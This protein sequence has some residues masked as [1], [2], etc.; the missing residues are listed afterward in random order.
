MREFSNAQASVGFLSGAD[1]LLTRLLLDY[2]VFAEPK[3]HGRAT[4]KMNKFARELRMSDREIEA[5]RALV[6]QLRKGTVT[7]NDALDQL[8]ALTPVHQFTLKWDDEPLMAA[9]AKRYVQALRPDSGIA[10]HETDR[11]K[12]PRGAN[13]AGRKAKAVPAA[14]ATAA[15]RRDPETFI[16]VGVF[17]TRDFKK[18]EVIGLKG[19]VADLTEEE[20]DEMRLSGGRSDFSVLWSE[21][22]NCFCL[23]LG[24]A[25]FVN[26]DCRNNV[27]FQLTGANMSFKVLE[28]IKKDEELFT[29]YGEH[30]FDKNNASCLC[31]TCEELKQGAFASKKPKPAE[32]KARASSPTAGSRKS[33]RASTI[34]APDY[35]ESR[36][37]A[38][39]SAGHSA[40][41]QRSAAGRSSAGL[42]RSSS[43]PSLAS[44]S[45]SSPARARPRS[46]RMNPTRGAPSPADALRSGPRGVI[47]PK[48]PPPPAYAKDYA[49]DAKRRVARYTGPTSC[50][51]DEA[52]LVAAKRKGALSRSQSAPSVVALGKR[53]RSTADADSPLRRS[54]RESKKPR[55]SVVKLKQVRLG[56]RSS[57]RLSGTGATASARDRTFAK[58]RMAMGGDEEDSDLSELSEEE[59]EEEEEEDDAEDEQAAD[60]DEAE[61]EDAKMVEA[62]LLSPQRSTPAA[63][64]TSAQSPLPFAMPS[65]T[66]PTRSSTG[67]GSIAVTATASVTLTRDERSTRS[68]TAETTVSSAPPSASTVA[69]RSLAV[70]VGMSTSTPA[71]ERPSP[72]LRYA[73][74]GSDEL[75]DRIVLCEVPEK[76]K[77]RASP[78]PSASPAAAASRRI[79]LGAPSPAFYSASG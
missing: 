25:R 38:S 72:Q 78:A 73:S 12:N 7:V 75:E 29:H 46:S 9:H 31:A 77:G 10:F 79:P 6:A 24:P 55:S 61:N 57:S 17:A 76:G 19:G 45:R 18:G 54:S 43:V 58:L 56:E 59:E 27:E 16:E 40:V 48:L 21:R 42:S 39:T 4:G 20:D 51:V 23:L 35:N 52:A 65:S 11:Y 34:A 5:T 50:P 1:D 41:A 47:Q 26:H 33:R 53:R 71:E 68:Q 2:A 13:A 3:L 22:K 69:V 60:D 70:E 64:A 44:T 14:V 66:R 49:W 62:E 36:P 74:D 37:I 28:D 67:S 15:A 30:Y 8:L 63:A 32:H